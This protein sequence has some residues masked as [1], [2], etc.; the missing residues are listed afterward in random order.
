MFQKAAVTA[1]RLLFLLVFVCCA[2]AGAVRAQDVTLKD[3]IQ[4]K[5]FKHNAD[6]SWHAED[7]SINYGGGKNQQQFNLFGPTAIRKGQP[8][9][10]VDLWVLLN[11]KCGTGH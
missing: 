4:C 7:V 8:V 11:E 1:I 5:D 6:G 3:A 9:N 2:T 10:G